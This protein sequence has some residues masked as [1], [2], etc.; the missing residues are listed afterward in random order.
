MKKI[1]YIFIC[2]LFLLNPAYCATTTIE[3]YTPKQ[4]KD[5]L[6]KIH[7]QKGAIVS[8]VT[9]YSMTVT[10]KGSFWANVF[11]GSNFN[12]Y[13]QVRTVYNFAQDNDNT[14]LNANVALVV[15]A[16]S[17][18]ENTVPQKDATAQLILDNLKKAIKGYYSYGFWGKKKKNYVL[19]QAVAPFNQDLQLGDK[20][21]KIGD[22]SLKGMSKSY[23]MNKFK[24][25]DANTELTILLIRNQ[26]EKEVVLK[27]RFIDPIY[28][29]E[30]L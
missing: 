14:I 23:I 9:D 30:K 18:F 22:E 16:G 4:L 28:T 24:V 5:L 27:S 13:T 8:N 19:V 26:Q 12:S 10:E 7:I 20:I 2:L 25:Y 15:N 6:M 11:Y 3:D 17:A 21:V 29:K 1:C